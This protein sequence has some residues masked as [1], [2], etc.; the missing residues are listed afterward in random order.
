MI[1]YI[2][3]VTMIHDFNSITMLISIITRLVNFLRSAGT[4]RN[5][6]NLWIGSPP[7]RDVRKCSQKLSFGRQRLCF[8]GKKKQDLA[9]YLS[10]LFK[11]GEAPL[12]VYTV[13]LHQFSCP[14]SETPDSTVEKLE[15]L[16]TSL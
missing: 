9:P 8:F 6:P 1:F 12:Q 13:H 11:G 16:S 3:G 7:H 4:L 14:V 5:M 10:G 15:R 2:L